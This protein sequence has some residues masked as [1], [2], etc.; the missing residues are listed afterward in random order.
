MLT[1]LYLQSFNPCILLDSEISSWNIVN[2]KPGDDCYE[3]LKTYLFAVKATDNTKMNLY[4]SVEGE[5]QIMQF[6]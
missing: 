6:G 3:E 4:V 1:D 5:I 2:M